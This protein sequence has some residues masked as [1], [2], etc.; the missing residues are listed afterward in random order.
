MKVWIGYTWFLDEPSEVTGVY[1]SEEEALKDSL[2]CTEFEIQG[3][4][5]QEII[6]ELC[7]IKL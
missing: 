1:W 5:S 4:P 7:S 3:T 2:E 6:E